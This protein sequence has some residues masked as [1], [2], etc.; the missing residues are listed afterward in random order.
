[1][2]NTYDVTGTCIEACTCG[3]GC[4]CC[5]TGQT[6]ETC[7]L[8]AAWT[9]ESGHFQGVDLAGLNLVG[10]YDTSCAGETPRG[11]LYADQTAT[12]A[13]RRALESLFGAERCQHP[14]A[15]HGLVT[16]FQSIRYS[17]VRVQGSNGSYRVEIPEVL[18]TTLSMIPVEGR[19]ELV[20]A[21]VGR[22]DVEA[23]A[24]PGAP[25]EGL[26]RYGYEARFRWL[27]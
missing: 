8:V 22:R 12:P 19:Q 18:S 21:G 24:E 9:I 3:A 23:A 11:I 17:D 26:R 7:Q 4:L 27:G 20:G 5:S 25:S 16:H 15:V 2:A 13:Q 14:A 6:Q 1:M 10:V